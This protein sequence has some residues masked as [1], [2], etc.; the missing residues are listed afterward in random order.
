M[1]KLLTAITLLCFSVGADAQLTDRFKAFLKVTDPNELQYLYTHQSPDCPFTSQEAANVIEGV[2]KRSRIRTALG[3]GRNNA[4]YL[5][6]E[7]SCIEDNTTSGRV[8]GYS[9]FFDINFGDG[10]M[11]YAK[12][13]GNLLGGGVSSSRQF[14]L[15]SLQDYVENAVTDFV[16]VNFLS[17]PN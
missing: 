12:P 15:N 10:V 9:V 1:K 3:I 17:D 4:I 13:Y 6:I 14:F 16:E 8:L 5:N 2:I 7:S 11:L